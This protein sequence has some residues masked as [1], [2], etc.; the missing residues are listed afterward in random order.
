MSMQDYLVWDGLYLNVRKLRMMADSASS[1]SEIL[2]DTPYAAMLKKSEGT[3][4]DVYF[5]DLEGG[6][7]KFISDEAAGRSMRSPL[8][9]YSVLHFLELKA[10]EYRAVRA[11]VLG[12]HAGMPP[13]D[14]RR[15]LS[16]LQNT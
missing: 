14:L 15:M 6:L 16:W 10:K 3:S 1:V 11:M 8:S 4:G 5:T 13:E 9:V 12:K 7:R 2:A